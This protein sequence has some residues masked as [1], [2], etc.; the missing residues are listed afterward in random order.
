MLHTEAVQAAEITILD[1][2]VIVETDTYEVR[3]ENGVINQLA[4]KITDEIY[5]LPPDING[6]SRGLGGR[7]GILRKGTSYLDVGG[8]TNRSKKDSPA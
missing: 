5:T 4:N 6:M 3:F 7:N 1:S 2:S 8:Y